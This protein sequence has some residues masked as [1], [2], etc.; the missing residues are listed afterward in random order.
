[1]NKPTDEKFISI[2]YDVWFNK[3]KPMEEKVARQEK[4]ITELESKNIVKVLLIW[5]Q[6]SR[7]EHQT[8]L[9]TIDTI[10]QSTHPHFTNFHKDVVKNS[11]E[12]LLKHEFGTE[13]NFVT[14][15]QL[16]EYMKKFDKLDAVEKQLNRRS[17]EFLK[18]VEKQK[19]ERRQL[20]KD[21]AAIRLPKF[22]S[23][24]FK[25]K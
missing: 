7:Y 13:K 18:E 22:L 3:Y 1:M 12:A 8:E 2:E 14:T 11:V 21:K 24:L 6:H 17:G 16:R 5:K 4:L 20:E 25:L 15:E 10:I 23:K 19:E 9:G